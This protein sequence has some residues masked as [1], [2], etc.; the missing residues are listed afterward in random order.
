MLNGVMF[1]LTGARGMPKR[2]KRPVAPVLSYSSEEV[3]C[4]VMIFSMAVCDK[5]LNDGHII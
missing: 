4:Y 3:P 2:H 5:F 1:I